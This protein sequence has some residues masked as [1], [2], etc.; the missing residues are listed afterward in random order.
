MKLK[1]DID[2]A[3]LRIPSKI[4]Y[5]IL[6]EEPGRRLCVFLSTEMLPIYF[7][8]F[9]GSD[10]VKH[11]GLNNNIKS[12]HQLLLSHE[13]VELSNLYKSIRYEYVD[14][15]NTSHH[16]Y[17]DVYFP[18]QISNIVIGFLQRFLS[19]KSKSGVF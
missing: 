5:P 15:F 4:P 19:L 9:V 11:N 16:M 10:N 14:R 1:I 6:I 7:I 13:S 12:I 3:T 18:K 8:D 17:L 2:F